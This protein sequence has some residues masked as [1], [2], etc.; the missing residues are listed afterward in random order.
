M[1]RVLPAIGLV[2]VVAPAVAWTAAQ[3]LN[4][5]RPSWR[6]IVSEN[7]AAVRVIAA[8]AATMVA[9]VLITGVLYGFSAWSEWW[10]RI[11]A[12]NADLATNEVTLRM[13]LA[14]VDQTAGTLI[15]ERRPLFIL[16]QL[17]SVLLVVRAARGRSLADGMLLSL[18]LMMLLLN[19]ANYH[20]HF[21]FL[22]VLLGAGRNLLATAAPLLAFCIVGYWIDLDPDSPRHFEQ[23]TIL[24]F[25]ALACIYFEVIRGR[26]DSPS[27]A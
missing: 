11:Q 27:V 23:L 21:I 9:I 14:G 18:P 22:L 1:L 26:P 5:R 19:P 13:L 8:A 25:A 20:V 2:G 4:R 15:R 7:R 3:W 12:L 17:A 6:A 16:A 10:F 24:L